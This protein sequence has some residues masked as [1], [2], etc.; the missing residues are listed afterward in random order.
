MKPAQ[1]RQQD[2]AEEA[3]PAVVQARQ[4]GDFGIL[5]QD[6]LSLRTE[7]VGVLVGNR[8]AG[9]ERPLFRQ[10]FDDNVVREGGAAGGALD[11][12]ALRRDSMEVEAMKP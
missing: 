2:P 5:G 9:L 10:E 6:V 12:V 7:E 4:P 8:F 1:D 11:N 3:E